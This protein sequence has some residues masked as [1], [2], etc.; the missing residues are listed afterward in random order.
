MPDGAFWLMSIAV[1][2]SSLSLLAHAVASIGT[3][4]A[5]KRL[6]EDLQPLIPEIQL[7]LKSAHDAV[8]KTAAEVHALVELGREVLNDVKT[9][10]GHIDSAR[11]ELAEQIRVHGQRLDLVAEDVLGRLQEVVGVFHNSVVRPVREVSGIVAGVR[12]AVQTFLLG[13]RSR[14]ARATQD[15]EMFI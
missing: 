11:V 9:Q 6:R 1:A 15:E 2:I 13:R 4:R 5:V 3:F 14:V 8:E 12:T 10:V 7:T